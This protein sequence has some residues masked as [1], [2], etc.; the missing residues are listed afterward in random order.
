MEEQQKPAEQ[1]NE[2]PTPQSAA[3]LPTGQPVTPNV[4]PLMAD[5]G[6][7]R[8]SKL[9]IVLLA[10]LLLAAA[11]GGAWYYMQDDEKPASS[12][13]QSQMKNQSENEVA[14]KDIQGTMDTTEWK[15]YSYEYSGIEGYSYP[16]VKFSFKYPDT[17]NGGPNKS[18]GTT[19]SQFPD[20]LQVDVTNDASLQDQG[21]PLSGYRSFSI[22]AT[23]KGFVGGNKPAV[24]EDTDLAEWA[25]ADST[26]EQEKIK[27][28]GYEAVR[29]KVDGYWNAWTI[30]KDGNILS[31]T[32]IAFDDGEIKE[33]SEEDQDIFDTI[34][35]TIKF[36]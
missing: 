24:D 25:G 13:N 27:I 30:K 10:V 1:S 35:S 14:V 11:G 6:K 29:F 26:V 21:G 22:N 4:Q 34:L 36:D 7:K 20:T 12:D 32:Y 31:F 18:D 3:T 15:T 8:P 17:W 9:L 28:G 2:I 33:L 23:L 19:D 16:T 5:G